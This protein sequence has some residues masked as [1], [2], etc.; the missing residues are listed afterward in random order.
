MFPA[1]AAAVDNARG[2]PLDFQVRL[3]EVLSHDDGKY[4]WYHPRAVVYPV[5]FTEPTKARPGLA[6][7]MPV[8]LYA[9]CSG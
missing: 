1:V 8:L 7:L 9:I 6:G 4:L 2:G 3:E 5:T